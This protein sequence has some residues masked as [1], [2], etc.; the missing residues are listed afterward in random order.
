M[1]FAFASNSKAVT[2]YVALRLVDQG[3]LSLDEPLNSYLAEPWLPASEYR[4]AITLR[5]VLSHSSGL[6]HQPISRE[7]LFAP[8]RGYSY[9]GV[10]ILYLQ[11]VIE[12]VTGQSLED[13]AQEMAFVPLGMSS[14][15]FVVVPAGATRP[16]NGHVHAAV[17]VLVFAVLYVIAIVIVGLLGLLVVRVGTGRWRPKPRQATGIFA[18]ALVLSLAAAS[19]LLGRAE[20][21]EFGWLVALVGL[22][23]A[24]ALALAFVAGRVIIRRL[25]PQRGWLRVAATVGWSGFILV[26]LV[27]GASRVTSLPVPQR[28][29]VEAG[30]AG[31]LRATAGD[32]ATFLIELADPQHLSPETAAQMKTSQVELSGDMSWGLGPGIQHSRQGDALWQWGQHLHFQSVMI[33]YPDHGFGV[34]VCTNN[35]MLNPHVAIEIAGRALGGKIEPIHRASQRQY[36]Y[37]EGT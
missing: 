4:D 9:S 14:S 13:V 8:G 2:A 11:A 16:A 37:R 33:I 19:V 31:S 21:P 7:N 20:L 24:V 32:M 10:G 34:V 17:P 12:E 36:D 22:A 3:V 28:S 35:D 25:V 29:R 27:L 23:V 26:G 1:A 5:H 30:A 18:A 15:S 6:R